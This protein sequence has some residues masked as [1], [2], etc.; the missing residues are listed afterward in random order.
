MPA[1]EPRYLLWSNRRPPVGPRYVAK[2]A[3]LRWTEYRQQFEGRAQAVT[4]QLCEA[5][6]WF[7]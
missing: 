7:T 6:R 3:G 5:T 4:I 1:G 2:L